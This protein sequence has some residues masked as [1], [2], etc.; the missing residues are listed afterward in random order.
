[1]FLVSFAPLKVRFGDLVA[2]FNV[3]IRQLYDKFYVLKIAKDIP[4]YQQSI[5]LDLKACDN[6]FF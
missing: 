2:F 5:S 1:M 4:V 3:F 6:L